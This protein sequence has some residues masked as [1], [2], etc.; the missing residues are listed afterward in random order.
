MSRSLNQYGDTFKPTDDGHGVDIAS[1][2]Q[3][4]LDLRSL[5]FIR[6]RVQAGRSVRAVDLGAGFGTH[7]LHMVEAGADV[8][9]VDLADMRG[10][11]VKASAVKFLQKD[12]AAM[13]SSDF[14]EGFDLL[15]SQRAIHYVPFA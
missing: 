4:E 8:T 7:A 9:M 6:E 15:Y 3:D 2:R 11:E 10:E 14:P 1:Q 13:D 5:A 12:F